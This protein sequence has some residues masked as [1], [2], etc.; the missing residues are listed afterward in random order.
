[1]RT[2]TAPDTGPRPTRRGHHADLTSNTAVLATH[3]H[4]L[5]TVH[6]A[7]QSAWPLTDNGSICI[8]RFANGGTGFQYHR[9][10]T[11]R[12]T[13]EILGEHTIKPT[14]T[15]IKWSP[16]DSPALNNDWTRHLCGAQGIR[17]AD[18]FHAME[19]QNPL[20]RWNPEGN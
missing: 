19:G 16:A 3:G 7:T 1:M 6:F 13:G 15:T 9:P 12:I 20:H 17:T 18:L 10:V 14:G 5:D 4:P 2:T 8:S 11:N